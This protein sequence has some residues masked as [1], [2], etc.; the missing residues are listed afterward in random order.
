MQQCNSLQLHTASEHSETSKNRMQSI[1]TFCASR[2]EAFGIRG[3]AILTVALGSVQSSSP[4]DVSEN[5]AEMANCLIWNARPRNAKQH[6]T[7]NRTATPFRLLL[8]LQSCCQHLAPRRRAHCC[9]RIRK[10]QHRLHSMG[11]RPCRLLRLSCRLGL[12]Y[13]ELRGVARPRLVLICIASLE[14]PK[15]HVHPRKSPIRSCQQ[16]F[17][18]IVPRIL[19]VFVCTFFMGMLTWFLCRG[20]LETGIPHVLVLNPHWHAQLGPELAL[21]QPGLVNSGL[22]T[23][24]H[25]VMVALCPIRPLLFGQLQGTN[26]R[27]SSNAATFAAMCT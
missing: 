8:L 4:D 2:R 1:S 22:H 27:G 19:Q 6:I 14:R 25:P 18:V 11:L 15:L 3:L 24:R 10:A 7:Q 20:H 13:F 16:Q 26:C 5:R 12:W 9:S 23:L 17:I 21:R